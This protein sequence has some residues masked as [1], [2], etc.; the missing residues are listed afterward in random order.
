MS[1]NPI[2]PSSIDL[3]ECQKK[4]GYRFQD[5]GLLEAALRH[6]SGVSHRLA[7]NER[8]EFLG[9]AILGAVVCE[10][11]FEMFP[12]YLEG[13]LTKVKSVVVSRDS[14]AKMTEVLGVEEYLLL[15]KGMA[16]D[17]EIPKSVVAATFESLVA[18]IHLD[19]GIEA[20]K[21]FILE[22]VEPVIEQTV[23][24]EFSDNFKSLLQQFGPARAWGNAQLSATGRKGP[25]PQ[26]VLQGL[27]AGRRPQIPAGLGTGAKRNRS[28][29]LHTTPSAT[30]T[31]SRSPTL[32]TTKR[33]SRVYALSR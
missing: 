27:G 9:D 29:G 24:G 21:Q 12:E 26:Q 31:A 13:E 19:G 6:A 5:V 3:E 8:M 4:I 28:S 15:G 30:S 18:A 20:A 25:R 22:Q 10:R 16:S 33:R 23:T 11:L 2:D 17:P 7:S 32:P 14:C 1:D